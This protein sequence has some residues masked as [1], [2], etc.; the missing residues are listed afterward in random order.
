MTDF[1]GDIRDARAL[2]GQ[3]GVGDYWELLKPRVMSLVVFTAAAGAI[4]APSEVHWMKAVVAIVC[5]AIGAG[6]SGA[7][8]QW[9]DADIDAIM[10]RTAGRPIPAGRVSRDAALEFGMVLSVFSVLSMAVMV[11]YLAAALLAF[12]I[13]FYAVIYT[14]GLKRWTA[15]NIV[16]GGAAGALPPVIA[17]AAVTG[18]VDVYPVLLF[19]LIFLWTPAHFWAL[20]LVKNEDYARAKV[21]MLPVVAGAAA[22]KAQILIYAVLTAAA[23]MAPFAMGYAGPAYG[24]VAAASSL[25]FAGLAL[26]L[27][28]TQSAGAAERRWAMRLFA[29][30]IGYLFLLFLTLGLESLLG[31]AP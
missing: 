13:F 5:I 25:G 30:S 6:A 19:L 27:W 10:A 1:S 29:F 14:M 26:R 3:A 11:G 21:P 4:V 20:A 15:Q 9:Y 17:W 2:A 7:L 31:G 23:A 12:T 28:R 18:S 24:A 16:I 22:T 8:N